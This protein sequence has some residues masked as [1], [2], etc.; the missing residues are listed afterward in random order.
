MK[1]LFALGAVL[2]ATTLMAGCY[3][4]PDYSYVR[5]G[6]EA[7]DAYVGSGVT[8]VYD[9]NG[10]DDA[11]YA[12]VYGGG[13]Y[14]GG[15]P[16]YGYGCCYSSGVAVGVS[17]TWVGGGGRYHYDDAYRSRQHYRDHDHGWYGRSDGDRDRHQDRDRDNEGYRGRDRRDR[18]NQQSRAGPDPKRR[19][20]Y[21][22]ERPP[23]VQ[24]MREPQQSSGERTRAASSTLRNRFSR[25]GRPAEQ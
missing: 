12:P 16:G 25:T 10:Y 3:Y 6:G 4:D 11:G 22:P 8:P 17:S 24:P 19:V 1:H 13:Y 18:E 2:A 15:Y 14:G 20:E 5:G 7:G 9:D 21:R 23:P